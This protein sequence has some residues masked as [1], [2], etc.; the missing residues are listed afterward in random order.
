VSLLVQNSI[1]GHIH[2]E[3][4]S[5]SLKGRWIYLTNYNQYFTNEAAK[6][7]VHIILD[8]SLLWYQHGDDEKY[9]KK[10]TDINHIIKLYVLGHWDLSST[11]HHSKIYP[12]QTNTEPGL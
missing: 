9:F 10:S 3:I 12:M 2:L 8:I 6:L 4:F 1:C 5:K 7:I 11:C